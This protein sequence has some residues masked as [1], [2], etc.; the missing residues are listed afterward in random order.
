MS[1]YWEIFRKG[2]G[3]KMECFAKIII[4]FNYFCKKLNLKSL[5]GF[6]IC[7]NFEYVRVLHILKF[8]QYGRVLNMHREA[9][10]E[11][12]WIFQEV[13]NF[14]ICLNMVELCTKAEFWIYLVN[15]SWGF[16][17]ASSSKYARSQN[18]AR[19]QI[20]EGYKGCWVWLNKPEYVLM[21]QYA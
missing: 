10:M 7:V 21:S 12:F 1:T 5:S 4:V 14:W 18:M 13:Y 9:I 15:F 6:W 11:E 17:W 8:L 2:H 19:L 3:P 16:K 20:C